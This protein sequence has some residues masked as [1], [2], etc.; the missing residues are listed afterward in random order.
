MQY[1]LVCASNENNKFVRRTVHL[2]NRIIT[3]YDEA[4]KKAQE[5]KAEKVY[6]E[7]FNTKDGSLSIIKV[8]KE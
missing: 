8:E 2:A 4:Y 5:V 3:D 1:R 7:I 6:I